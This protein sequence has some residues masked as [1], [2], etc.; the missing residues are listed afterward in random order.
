M[1]KMSSTILLQI[2][3]LN[4]LI[5]NTFPGMPITWNPKTHIWIYNSS[6]TESTSHHH[7]HGLNRRNLNWHRLLIEIHISL[8]ILTA[9]YSLGLCVY[10]PGLLDVKKVVMIGLVG[11][12]IMPLVLLLDYGYTKYARESYALI[13]WGIHKQYSLGIAKR[14]QSHSLF[15]GLTQAYKKLI[16]G[17]KGESI[18]WFG[19]VT[20]HMF[21]ALYPM[22]V[23]IPFFL[24]FQDQDL[25]YIWLYSLSSPRLINLYPYQHNIPLKIFRSLIQSF[26]SQSSALTISTCAITVMN[27]FQAC[28]SIIA[29]LRKIKFRVNLRDLNL[30][31]QLFIGISIQNKSVK[32][33]NT[34]FLSSSFFVLVFSINLTI[35][36]A[37]FLP[38]HVYIMAPL[39]A[40]CMFAFV[41]IIFMVE[42]NVYYETSKLLSDWKWLMQNDRRCKSL[43]LRK[44][45]R[46]LRPC[47]FPVGEIGIVDQDI[48]INYLHVVFDRSV[49]LLVA[50]QV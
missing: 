36:G 8:F 2:N 37:S 1:N 23:V 34:L 26:L 29:H 14:T 12:T 27:M 28:L 4:Q 38:F 6:G 18:D 13:N 35:L 3:N 30:Y 42:G 17:S 31:K 48:K 9:L 22:S 44:T 49:D 25:T 24:V 46:S 5:A 39:I 11:V 20:F 50:L 40:L 10:Y 7:H 16:C 45:L 47:S 43:G 19:V 32:L 41:M 33:T 21:I 15:K